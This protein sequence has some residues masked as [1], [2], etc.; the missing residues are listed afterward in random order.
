VANTFARNGERHTVD[1][2]IARLEEV[3]EKLSPLL[4]G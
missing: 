1:G 2:W 4:P 3:T